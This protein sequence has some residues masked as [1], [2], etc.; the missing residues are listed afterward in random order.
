MEYAGQ[1]RSALRV[2][3]GLGTVLSCVL[4]VVP[5]FPAQA[6]NILLLIADDY[7]VDSSAIY[8]STNF[9]ASLPYTPNLAALA[10]GGVVFGHAYANPVCSPSRA[11]MV[12]GRHAFRT[13]IGDAILDQTSPSLQAAEFTLPEAFAA[14]GG[15]G[16]QLAQFGK[17]HLGE[18]AATPNTIGGWPHY[19]GCVTHA[20][21]SYTNWP[22]TVNGVVSPGYTPYATSDVVND[23]I[24]WIQGR[25]AQPWF[26]WVAF[27]SPHIPLHKPPTNLCPDYAWIPGTPA[28]IAA[29]PRRYYEAMVQA[30]D[31]EIGR[32]LAAVDHTN[33]DIIFVSDN[34]TPRRVIQPPFPQSH[35]KDSLYEGGIHV[36]LIVSGPDVVSPGRTNDTPVHVA[37]LFAT[38]LELAGIDVATT[39]GT[40][41]VVDSRSFVSMLQSDAQESRTVYSELF[42]ADTTSGGQALRGAPFKLIDFQDD[43][44][45]FYDLESDPYEGTNLLDGV[46]N[47]TQQ[48]HYYDLRRKLGAYQHDLTASHI[49]NCAVAGAGISVNATWDTNLT[50]TLWRAQELAELAWTPVSNMGVVIDGASITLID[51]QAPS[52]G[53]FYQLTAVPP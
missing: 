2:G 34:G 53:A 20:V 13:G 37:D 49:T 21:P 32:L 4:A 38:I 30:M 28:D 40:N 35:A 1:Q 51:S 16:Y 31:T 18:Q 14:N 7:G 42:G 46:L 10:A 48:A 47:A 50:Y 22:K 9:G 39:L 26:A 36:P 12:T 11:C 15:L 6:R 3:A 45:E 44:E 23:A 43:P 29:N 5:A 24:L 27:N 8:N 19:A 17:W 25:G 33:A 41:A 52:A